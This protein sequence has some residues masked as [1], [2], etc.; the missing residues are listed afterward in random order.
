MISALENKLSKKNG[1]SKYDAIATLDLQ[2]EAL[3]FLILKHDLDYVK[4]T[5]TLT[6]LTLHSRGKRL[7]HKLSYTTVPE[8]YQ[9]PENPPK[10]TKGISK[11]DFP[12]K[13][14]V[15][16]LVCSKTENERNKAYLLIVT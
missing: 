8:E 10:I 6:I 11:P 13:H 16:Q 14:E 4:K 3:T 12:E 9:N 1:Y 5:A 15:M 2:E 7:Q